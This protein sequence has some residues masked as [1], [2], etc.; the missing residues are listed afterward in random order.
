VQEGFDSYDAEGFSHVKEHRADQTSRV[1]NPI[2][3]V[4]KANQP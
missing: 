4:N 2:Y 1:K 3:A